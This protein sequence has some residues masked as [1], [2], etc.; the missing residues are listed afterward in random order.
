MAMY[1]SERTYAHW[2]KQFNSMPKTLACVQNLRKLHQ[3]KL[4]RKHVKITKLGTAKHRAVSH[5]TEAER[6]YSNGQS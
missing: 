4:Q 1:L 6:N 3:P 2:I 5:M